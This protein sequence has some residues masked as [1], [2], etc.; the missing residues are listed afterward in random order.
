VLLNRLFWWLRSCVI[1]PNC[2]FFKLIMIKIKLKKSSMTYFNDV[3]VITSPI[4]FTNSPNSVTKV[5]HFGP[6]PIKIF[7]YASDGVV[8]QLNPIKLIQTCSQFR[9]RLPL[10]Y[11]IQ[12]QAV[13]KICGWW[14]KNS[15]SELLKLFVSFRLSR[16][17]NIHSNLT[18]FVDVI[19]H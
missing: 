7:G 9:E 19:G 8:V 12:R 14:I 3:I 11:H 17:W 13:L 1:W 10:Q 15:F 16:F 5:F 6:P 2:V 4:N 18:M